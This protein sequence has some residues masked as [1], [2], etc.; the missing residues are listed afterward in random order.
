VG[1]W[2]LLPCAAASVLG[3]KGREAPKHFARSCPL[4]IPN[5][6]AHTTGRNVEYKGLN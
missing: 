1:G 6:A 4:A 3:H 5:Q 2:M